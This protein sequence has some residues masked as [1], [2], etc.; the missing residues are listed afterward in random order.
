MG[1]V[2]VLSPIFIL[3]EIIII[4]IIIILIKPLNV[5]LIIITSA[6]LHNIII[7][8]RFHEVYPLNYYPITLV[9]LIFFPKLLQNL[10]NNDDYTKKLLLLML[11]FV[12]WASLSLLWT[13]DVWRGLNSFFTLLASFFIF[14]IFL[15]MVEDKKALYKLLYACMLLGVGLGMILSFSIWYP[16]EKAL[17]IS[18]ELSL[19]F[20]VFTDINRPGGFALADT[21]AAI[22]NR[23]VFLS[24]A[25]M[26]KGNFSKKAIIALIIVFFMI[27]TTVTASKAGVA[28][29]F[30]GIIVFIVINATWKDRRLRI[31]LCFLIIVVLLLLMSGNL[32]LSRTEIFIEKGAHRGFIND[33]VGYWVTGI[34]QMIDTCG[35]G[36]GVG[37]MY[38][39][40]KPVSHMH[41]FYVSVIS[42]LGLI[43]FSIFLLM[44]FLSLKYFREVRRTCMDKEMIFIVHCFTANIVS[45]AIHIL[46]EG[47]L[48]QTL[49]IAVIPALMVT[50]LKI[51]FKKEDE[52]SLSTL[53]ENSFKSKRLA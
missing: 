44:I 29:L 24:F 43:G 52:A 42:E 48:S 4:A 53:P 13:N 40:L 25:L 34:T 20:S 16:M 49:F 26:Y 33:R 28:T 23:F 5:Y 36:I 18:D 8:G 12:G 17:K 1:I 15:L 7:R 50:V 46:V 3:V 19:V 2:S 41:N 11:V 6:F 47:D 30:I 14:Q 51:A 27:C 31:G 10:K 32:L 9:Y 45:L 39:Y 35:I 38:H 22:M 37:G 21:A